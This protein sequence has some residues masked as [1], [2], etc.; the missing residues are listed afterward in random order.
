YGWMLSTV[1]LTATVVPAGAILIGVG[2]RTGCGVSPEGDL[3]VIAALST[4]GAA[5]HMH[6]PTAMQMHQIRYFLVLAAQLNF[7]RSAARC[8]VAQPS[9]TRAIKAL[10]E[11][12]G[13]PLFHRDHIHSQLTELGKVVRPYLEDVYRG[14]ENAR[15]KAREYSDS[16]TMP[17]RLGLMC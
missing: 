4:Q 9:L 8:N 10:E 3:C 7:T 1:G 15:R 16:K 11:E 2:A 14:A 13:G 5:A 12:L 6:G 17:L